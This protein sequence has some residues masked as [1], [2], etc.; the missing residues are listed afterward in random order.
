MKRQLIVLGLSGFIFACAKAPPP[1]PK[2][3]DHVVSVQGETLAAI[4]KW[5]TGDSSNWSVILE[6]NPGLDVR[7]IRIGTTI[8]IPE[9]LVLRDDPFPR[10]M[11]MQA[12]DKAEQAKA[13]AAAAKMG[14][15]PA[16]GPETQF[17]EKSSLPAPFE[18]A[19][20]APV[21][22]APAA[23]TTA[24]VVPHEAPAQADAAAAAPAEAVGSAAQEKPAAGGP[25]KSR[26]ELL[27]ELLAE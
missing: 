25:S 21:A 17:V 4:A 18:G 22:E 14:S 13:E 6:H 11:V 8:Q 16:A 19:P 9:E 15:A 7:R 23:E 24:A 27:K 2:Y 5:Y 26:D 1:P 12:S 20:A 10:K 3:F